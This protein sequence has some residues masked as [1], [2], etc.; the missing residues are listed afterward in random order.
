MNDSYDDLSAETTNGIY[1]AEVVHRRGFL[2]N[3]QS[4]EQPPKW[5]TGLIP[6]VCLHRL[7]L[8]VSWFPGRSHLQFRGL[9]IP[10]SHRRC[11]DELYRL[12]CASR[13]SHSTTR[14]AYSAG[15]N[16]LSY[17][18]WRG[19]ENIRRSIGSK[20]ERGSVS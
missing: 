16:I 14:S 19:F 4:V 9:S 12:R 17:M 7:Q 10:G 3:V 18:E 1:K 20:N 6:G 15:R 2:R 11:S 8:T 13:F 5:A